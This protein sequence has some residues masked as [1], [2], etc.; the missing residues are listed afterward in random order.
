[1]ADKLGPYINTLMTTVLDKKQEQFV[2]DL[3][4]S[5][6]KRLNADVEEFLRKHSKDDKEEIE[7]T[8]QLLQEKKN[9]KTE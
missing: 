8:K 5:E 4:W 6:L 3:A 9:D 2:K 1:M 7:N